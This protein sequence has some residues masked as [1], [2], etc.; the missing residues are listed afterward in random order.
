LRE[1]HSAQN[2]HSYEQIKASLSGESVSPHPSQLVFKF[3]CP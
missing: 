2:V 1:A 3:G